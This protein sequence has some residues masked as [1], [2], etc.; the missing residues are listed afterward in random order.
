MEAGEARGAVWCISMIQAKWRRKEQERGRPGPSVDH[1]EQETYTSV[2][3]WADLKGH[4]QK[5][6]GV[7]EKNETSATLRHKAR[8]LGEGLPIERDNS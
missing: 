4:I 7:K 6:R 1:G 5:S 3:A 8:D 2:D